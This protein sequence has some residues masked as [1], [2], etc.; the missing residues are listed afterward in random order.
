[1][2][3]LKKNEKIYV[4]DNNGMYSSHEIYFVKSSWP[5]NVVKKFFKGYAGGHEIIG[6]FSKLDWWNGGFRG[7]PDGL[8]IHSMLY[9]EDDW[10]FNHYIKDLPKK[11]LKEICK[12][13]AADDST[14]EFWKEAVSKAME[15]LGKDD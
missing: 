5:Q 2:K 15:N 4:I 12:K 8:F 9:D 13:C 10:K 6:V 3:N 7:I 14:N 1:M 11:Y